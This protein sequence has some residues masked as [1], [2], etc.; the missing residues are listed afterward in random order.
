MKAID[1][2]GQRFERL[3]VVSYAG[4]QGSK[5]LWRCVCDCSRVS[6]VTSSNLVTGQTKSCGCMLR[7]NARRLFRRHGMTGTR[8]HHIWCSMIQRCTDRNC[9]AF[10]HYGGRGI[11]VCERWAKFENFAADMGNPPTGMTLERIKNEGNYEPGNC[12]WATCIEQANNK[13]SNRI[14][15]IN[16]ERKTLAQWFRVYRISPF[17]FYNRI[18]VGMTEIEAL[19][20]PSRKKVCQTRVQI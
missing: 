8:I 6:V 5:A 18:R 3:T 20:K 7:E 14:I 12:K 19:T 9:E 4:K 17:G 2:T 16:G 10:P 1:R 13:R 15:E 11:S